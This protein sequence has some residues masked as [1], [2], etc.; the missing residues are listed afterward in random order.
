[1]SV[2]D[3]HETSPL[4]TVDDH[5]ASHNENPEGS[6]VDDAVLGRN[7]QDGES[8]VTKL[9]TYTESMFNAVDNGETYDNVPKDKRQLG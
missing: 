8:I 7:E 1:M 4:L 9:Q 6:A 5:I 2:P 3:S